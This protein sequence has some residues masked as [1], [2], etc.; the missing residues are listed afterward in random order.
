MRSNPA[1]QP[2]FY[3]RLENISKSY[4]NF[5]TFNGRSTDTKSLLGLLLVSFVCLREQIHSKNFYRRG[6]RLSSQCTDGVDTY[7]QTGSG[8][9]HGPYFRTRFPR[10]RSF[11]CS[12]VLSDFNMQTFNYQKNS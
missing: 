7:V 9:K 2:F 4:L 8:V 6:G 3:F 12:S 1:Q 10:M 11:D 5:S